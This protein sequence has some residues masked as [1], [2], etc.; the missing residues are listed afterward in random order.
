M[1][2]TRQPIPTPTESPP[3]EA[4]DSRSSTWFG[5]NS[6]I[7][8][9]LGES[10]DQLGES[11]DQL[12]GE[13]F[14]WLFGGG[15]GVSTDDYDDQPSSP[16]RQT[17][18][19]STAKS[20][21]SPKEPDDADRASTDHSTSLVVSHSAEQTAVGA[22]TTHTMGEQTTERSAGLTRSAEGTGFDL[23]QKQTTK[24]EDGEHASSVGGGLS[25]GAEG[26]GGSL[27]HGLE[28]AWTDEEG[29][30]HTAASGQS[31]TISASGIQISTY[32]GEEPLDDWGEERDGP[33]EEDFNGWGNEVPWE[34]E[35]FDGDEP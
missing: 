3:A 17:T 14:G 27:E 9:L 23:S 24:D 7:Q 15:D 13:L 35:A 10:P 30:K 28:H 1:E 18:G 29:N 6:F 19:A 4:K 32:F 12:V 16:A 21:T 34:E 11:P 22:Q 33:F 25:L 5:D 8:G 31:A 20:S 26:L 2:K